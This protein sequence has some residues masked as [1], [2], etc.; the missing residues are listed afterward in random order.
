MTIK[1]GDKVLVCDC[2]LEHDVLYIHQAPGDNR[3]YYVVAYR[4]DSPSSYKENQLKKVEPMTS[5]WVNIYTLG[6][7]G[8]A[9]NSRK[10]ADINSVGMRVGV[11]RIDTINGV[12]TTHLENV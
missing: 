1:V 4:G 10:E 6:Y 8:P 3:V 12:S 11:V 9:Y 2:D 5:V 7:S